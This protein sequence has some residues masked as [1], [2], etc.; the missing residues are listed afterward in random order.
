MNCSIWHLKYNIGVNGEFD[1]NFEKNTKSGTKKIGQTMTLQK[2]IDMGEYDPKFLANFSEWHT[3]TKFM[4]WR[5]IREAIKNRKRFLLMQWADINN[6]LDF[7]LKPELNEA[8][9]NIEKQ[10]K[11]LG[12]R[13]EKLQLEYSRG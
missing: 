6:V 13:E 3:L 11:E 9:R 4:Q 10:Q 12:E 8:L 2:A 7:R 1:I 5:Y